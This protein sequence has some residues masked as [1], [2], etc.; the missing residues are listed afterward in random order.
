MEPT[1]PKKR[2]NIEK[3]EVEESPAKKSRSMS[4][5]PN[6]VKSTL[7]A[8]TLSKIVVFGQGRSGNKAIPDREEDLSLEDRM[9]LDMKEVSISKSI[10]R[11]PVDGEIARIH[12]EGN[13]PGVDQNDW[14]NAF[15][16]PHA[17]H[18]NQ[19][20]HSPC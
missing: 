4:Q 13:Q 14:T 15:I 6:K 10:V 5:T 20:R 18:K 9:M 3:G 19:S 7:T 1:T 2:K 12:L 11:I 16:S 17:L 8:L